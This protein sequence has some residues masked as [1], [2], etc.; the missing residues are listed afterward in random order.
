MRP[1]PEH[2]QVRNTDKNT[3]Q[4]DPWS[5]GDPTGEPR[6][7]AGTVGPAGICACKHVEKHSINRAKECI[8]NFK[9]E[10]IL[11]GRNCIPCTQN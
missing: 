2:A 4:K 10:V 7:N 11:N 9:K 5:I 3:E 8:R 1:P 6:T